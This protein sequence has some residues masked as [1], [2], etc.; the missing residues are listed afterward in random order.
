MTT[1]QLAR[2]VRNEHWN[3][4]GRVRF[5]I[6]PFVIAQR[7]NIE[8]IITPLPSDTAGFLLKEEGESTVRAYLNSADHPRR[9]RFTL[10]HEIGHF[11]RHRD[12]GPMGYVEERAALASQGTDPEERFANRFA[13]DLL[14]PAHIV[15][16]D[17]GMGKSLSDMATKYNVSKQSLAF[18]LANLGLK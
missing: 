6:D 4:N 18:R 15:A 9:Q 17:W 13:A 1:S 3:I 12:D 11:M 10:A 16:K 5:P 7:L 8:V 2:D 14:M